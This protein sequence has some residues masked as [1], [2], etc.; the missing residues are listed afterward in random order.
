MVFFAKIHALYIEEKK[1]RR[2]KKMTIP[3]GNLP[4][5][6]F[7]LGFGPHFVQSKNDYAMRESAGHSVWVWAWVLI[8]CK[9]DPQVT[10]GTP[11]VTPDTP[12]T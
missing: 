9:E 5:I 12:A 3:R 6:L 10:P 7:G 8:L 11:P 4:E 1:D 2:S